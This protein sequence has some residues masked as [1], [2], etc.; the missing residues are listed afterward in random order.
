MHEQFDCLLDSILVN[1]VVNLVGSGSG[2]LWSIATQLIAMIAVFKKFDSS[3]TPNPV[4]NLIFRICSLKSVACNLTKVMNLS[5]GGQE[6]AS[7]LR[8]RAGVHRPH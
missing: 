6:I 7:N 8:R 2:S 3:L 4:D 1:S 5:L